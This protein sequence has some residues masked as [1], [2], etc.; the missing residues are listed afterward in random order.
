MIRAFAAHGDLQ[1]TLPTATTLGELAV[2]QGDLDEAWR[3]VSILWDPPHEGA[4]GYDLPLLGLAARI[5]G[6]RRRVGARVPDDAVDILDSVFARMPAWP[7]VPRW[8]ALV[9]AELSGVDGTGT[10][11]EAWRV[12]VAELSDESMPAH[13]RAYTW[14]RLGG[15]EL[16]A[17]DRT[18]AAASLRTAAD[19]ADR[20]G[21]TWISNRARELLQTAGLGERPKSGSELLTARERQVLELIAEG[22]SNREISQRLFISTKT[23]SV[24][25]SS[26]LRKLGASSRTQA[27]MM[28]ERVPAGDGS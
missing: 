8:R 19:Q 28:A 2:F 10:D 26:I 4:A 20:I 17:G 23:T 3:Q 1:D 11:V 18:V 24:H 12:A 22:L 25:V 9:D 13:L 21:A 16:G 14:W 6:E 5:I 15:V 7:T 27:A